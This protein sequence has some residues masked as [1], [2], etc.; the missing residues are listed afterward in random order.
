MKLSE[1]DMNLFLV[2]RTVLKEGNATRA[3]ARLHVTQSAVSNALARL[4]RMFGDPLVVPVA[5]GLV[6][7]PRALEVLPQLEA[8]LDQLSALV[9]ADRGFDPLASERR[10]TIAWIDAVELVLLPQLAALVERSLPR[11]ALRI[12]TIDRMV[13]TDGLAS[14]DVDLLIGMPPALPP[15]CFAEDI[16]EDELV[17]VVRRGH[18]AARARRMT[19]ESYAAYPHVE[20][21]LFGEPDARVDAALA[22]LRLARRVAVSVPHFGAVAMVVARTDAIATLSRRLVAALAPTPLRVLPPPIALPPLSIRQVWHARVAHDAGTRYLR[23]EAN[24]LS[25]GA[26]GRSTGVTAAARR[27]GRA[28]PSPE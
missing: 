2:L 25:Q 10:F 18:P 14:G 19:L 3:A 20:F 7:T 16:Y 24:R 8:A 21:A 5:R 11:A 6:A 15:G 9:A 22:Q 13:A 4:R 28:R 1:V 26:A 12:V 23:A 27:R 17:C